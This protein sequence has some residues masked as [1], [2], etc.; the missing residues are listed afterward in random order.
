MLKFLSKIETSATPGKEN[1]LYYHTDHLGSSG[2][3]TDKRGN[4]YE[5]TEYTSSGESWVNEKVTGNADL[6]YK[7]T[8]KEQDAETGLY[9][10]GARYRDAKT[11]VWLSCDPYIS[12]GDY[13]PVPP[14]NDKTKERNKKLP[15]MGGVFNSVNMNAYHYA[16]NNPVKYID[17][18]GNEDIVAVKTD[19]PTY[20]KFESTVLVYSDGTL[21]KET[22]AELSKMSAIRKAQGGHLTKS[23]VESV[24]GKANRAYENFSTLP[25][26][27]SIYGTAAEGRLYTYERNDFTS[28]SGAKMDAFLLSDPELWHTAVP[29]DAAYN[30]G[31][32]PSNG[33]RFV[34]GSHFHRANAGNPND[35]DHNGSGSKGC[36]TGYSPE[37]YKV[38]Y[39]SLI[40]SRTGDKGH[41]ILF[42]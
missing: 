40:S 37:D 19:N 16:G 39:N 38:F 33:T 29:Q 5:H 41:A 11:G 12:S 17:P 23:D 9:Y 2:Y 14:V 21:T 27:P 32:N 13:F 35:V 4:F 42:R 26:D 1:T 25:N 34:G 7:Y 18:D 31:I 15:G 20:K 30:N 10:H 22:V 28:E 6:P 8:S 24:L 36:I 3:V